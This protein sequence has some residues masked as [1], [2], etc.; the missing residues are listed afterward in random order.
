MTPLLQFEMILGSIFLIVII[1]LIVKKG[2]ISLKY[3]MIWILSSLFILFSSIFPSTL[4]KISVFFNFE[5]LS[6]M[7]FVIVIIILL[8]ISLS[9][10]IIVTAQNEKIRLLIQEVS[11][12]KKNTEEK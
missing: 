1:I 10:T 12:I 4:E 6:N 3:S 11:K 7:L 9:L 8:L 2:L 5:T